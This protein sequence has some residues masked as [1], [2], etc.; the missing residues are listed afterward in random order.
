[1]QIRLVQ[2]S[3]ILALGL[4]A[5]ATRPTVTPTQVTSSQP[6][7][8]P[9]TVFESSAALMPRAVTSFGAAELGGSV[10]AYGGYSGIPHAYNREGQ[11]GELWRLDPGARTFELVSTTPERRR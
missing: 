10:Y 2:L 11:S 1:M 5:C 3:S 6:A 4:V 9:T 7:A 8:V